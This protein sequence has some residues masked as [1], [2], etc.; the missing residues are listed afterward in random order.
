VFNVIYSICQVCEVLVLALVL[1]LKLR[2]K[3]WAYRM[4]MQRA[5]RDFFLEKL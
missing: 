2:D 1:E 5:E 3:G 4:G